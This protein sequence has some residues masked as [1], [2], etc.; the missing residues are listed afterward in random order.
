MIIDIFLPCR[1]ASSRV[2][3]KN[4]KKFSNKKFGLLEIKINQLNLVKNI[5]NI[6][7]STNDKK[8]IQYLESKKF[9]KIIID[10]R[11]SDLCTGKTRT[12]DLIKYVPKIT[13]AD[14]ILWT[15][16][17]SPFF[18][19]TDYDLAIKKYKLNLKKNDSLMGVTKLQE[20]IYDK[21]KPINFNKKKE[22][23]PRT[24]TLSP[25][26]SVNSTVFINSRKNYIKFYDRIGKKPFLMEIE[27]IKAFD[28]DWSDDFKI[29][30]NIYESLF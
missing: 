22:K 30:E 7:V 3:N 2:K 23:W 9:D 6:V 10:K 17:T 4:I 25:L 21:K 19:N 15:H 20:F 11:R 12:D 13:D 5:R 8:I 1:A 27:K 26:Y 18:D 29:A 14:H 24:Q 16:V 28:I